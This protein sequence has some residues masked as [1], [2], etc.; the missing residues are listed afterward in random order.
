MHQATTLDQDTT[1]RCHWLSMTSSGADLTNRHLG[2]A[3]MCLG[4][5]TR[6]K[7][8]CA[9]SEADRGPGS[10]LAQDALATDLFSGCGLFW[11]QGQKRLQRANY[12]ATK[13]FTAQTC[14]IGCADQ[15]TIFLHNKG[16]FKPTN[17]YGKTRKLRSL[18]N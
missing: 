3:P 15:L 11:K 6:L 9:P 5:G 1:T 13:K 14:M 12:Q 10:S 7:Q 16:N 2:L 8:G 18:K 4:Y 17:K